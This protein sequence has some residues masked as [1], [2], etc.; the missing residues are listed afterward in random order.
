VSFTFKDF[1]S[2]TGQ[3]QDTENLS[4]DDLKKKA[5]EMMRRA[6]LK[7]SGRD[8]Q[9]DRLALRDLQQQLRDADD[10]RKKVDIQRRITELTKKINQ[11]QQQRGV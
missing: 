9:V 8:E 11:P 1:L 2:E 5:Q 10:P 6:Q 7:S 3:A 4:A